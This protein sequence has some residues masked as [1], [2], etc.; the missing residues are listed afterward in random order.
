MPRFA[1]NLSFMFADRPLIER[2]GAAAA[3]GFRAVELQ[4][5]YEVAAKAVRAE[6]DR[7]GLTMLGINTGPLPDTNW[8]AAGVPGRE[9]EF[10]AL[11]SQALDYVVTIGGR[12]IHCLAGIVTPEQRAVAEQV[13]V[14]NLQ[15]AADRAAPDGIVILIE[16]INTRDCPGYLLSTAEQA[17]E[18]LARVQ[19]PNVRMQFDFYHNQIMGGDLIR[20][21][22]RYR[23]IIGHVQIAAVPSR[24]EPDEGEIRYA[25]IFEALDRLHYEGWVGC[26]YKPRGLTEDGLSWGT[27]YGLG[28]AARQAG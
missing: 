19:R 16:P 24:A 5:P 14:H 28:G 12:A 8:G 25:G 18:I 4:A 22:E 27:A 10:A 21:F 15:H 6:I 2:F 20:R 11:F 1:A 3:A 7:H 17:A 26:E 9:A 23:A 13:F